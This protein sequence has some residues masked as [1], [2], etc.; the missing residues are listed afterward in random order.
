MEVDQAVAAEVGGHHKHEVAVDLVGG[1][2]NHIRRIGDEGDVPVRDGDGDVL[3]LLVGNHRGLFFE[4]KM[5]VVGEVIFRHDGQVV[6]GH[7]VDLGALHGLLP[8]VLIDPG[9]GSRKEGGVERK[10]VVLGHDGTD[11]VAVE[12]LAVANHLEQQRDDA[13]AAVYGVRVHA[14][15]VI[16]HGR[17]GDVKIGEQGTLGGI[18]W[19]RAL[20]NNLVE[21]VAL[22]GLVY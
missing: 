8:V 1:V 16:I 13:V 9:G 12:V 10:E 14:E 17:R 11:G 20:T 15:R 22:E 6:E 19:F 3:V 2:N 4:A 21:C 7:R 18:V 5:E